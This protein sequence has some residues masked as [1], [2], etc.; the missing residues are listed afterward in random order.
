M[1][2]NGKMSPF[3]TFPGVVGRGI[4]ES[5]GGGKFNYGI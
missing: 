2:V 1:N 5:D 3:V 4:T